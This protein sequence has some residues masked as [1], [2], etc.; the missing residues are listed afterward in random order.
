ML[1]KTLD[2]RKRYINRWD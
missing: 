1:G 2:K